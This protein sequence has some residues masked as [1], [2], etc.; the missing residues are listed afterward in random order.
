MIEN[1]LKEA[2]QEHILTFLNRLDGI[3]LANL[4]KQI[5][6]FDLIK[7]NKIFLHTWDYD[8]YRKDYTKL[9]PITVAKK[10]HNYTNLG[11][12][13]FINN[14]FGVVLL[15]GGN[16]S[17]LNMDIPKGCLEI[18]VNN[19]PTSLFELY[20]NQ[21]KDGY[22]KYHNYINLYIMTNDET[23]DY[24][25]DYFKSHNYFDYPEDK[26][27]FFVQDKLPITGVDGRLL[28]KDEKTLLVGPNGNGDVYH[29]LKRN[30]LINHMLNEDIKYVLFLTIDNVMNKLIDPDCL[31]N[32]INGNYKVL[33][34]SIQKDDATDKNWVFCKYN[35]HPSMWPTEDLTDEITN[36]YKKGD[37]LYRDKNITYHIIEIN[38]LIKYSDI[39]LVYDRAYKQYDYLDLDGNLI[40]AKEKNTFKYE[41]F[42]FDAFQYSDDMLIYRVDK[43]EFIPIKTQEDI[44]KVEDILN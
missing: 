2:Y 20:I 33:S 26:I 35:D 19:K 14:Q 32:M 24:I 7:L 44:K 23:N 9:S 41:I 10:N 13:V 22:K 4:E 39:K 5:E 37:Y 29:A 40:V 3:D 42:I 30:K 17:R 43:D 34:K 16:A 15:A 11:E 12:Q 28:M 25:I 8:Y 31:G 6:Y 1:K 21:L 36:M 38:E 27:H 18:N